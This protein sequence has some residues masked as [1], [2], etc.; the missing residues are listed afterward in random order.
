M[1]RETRRRIL[2]EPDF[3]VA[4]RHDN[5]LTRVV[6]AQKEEKHRS[7]AEVARAEQLR[8]SRAARFLGM[9]TEDVVEIRDDALDT[10]RCELEE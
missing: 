7:V 5:S 3:V 4:P 1:D 6:A 8:I 9:S 10:L 2:D